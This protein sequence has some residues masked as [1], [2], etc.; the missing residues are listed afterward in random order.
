MYRTVSVRD[1]FKSHFYNLPVVD[2]GCR[3][4]LSAHHRCP[5]LQ[6]THLA[7]ALPAQTI[8][9]YSILYTSVYKVFNVEP[10]EF[11]SVGGG[12]D[13]RS[14]ENKHKRTLYPSKTFAYMMP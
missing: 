5:H 10:P 13:I 12:P 2:R 14:A 11:L 1:F 6:S 8:P 9:R 4:L 7:T 3:P